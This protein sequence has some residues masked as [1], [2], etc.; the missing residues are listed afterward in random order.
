MKNSFV[1]ATKLYHWAKFAMGQVCNG[2]RLLWAEIVMDR[3][4]PEPI[5]T[6]LASLDWHG[7]NTSL[8]LHYIT[9]K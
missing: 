6:I 1:K 8:L 2:L 9:E 4:V 3:V 7:S 5:I